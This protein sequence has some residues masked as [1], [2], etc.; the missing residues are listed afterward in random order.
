M[1]TIWLAFALLIV[2]SSNRNVKQNKEDL[3]GEWIT[4]ADLSDGKHTL[5]YVLKFEDDNNFNWKITSYEGTDSSFSYL[6]LGTFIV[7]KNNISFR[8]K[9]QQTWDRS[10]SAGWQVKKINQSLFNSCKYKISGINLQLDYITYP[11]DGPSAT[12][13]IYTRL[14]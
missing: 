7:H 13:S 6:Y 14:R 3:S 11:G 4:R 12:Q 5:L 2:L 9:E 8:A 1:K 10:N